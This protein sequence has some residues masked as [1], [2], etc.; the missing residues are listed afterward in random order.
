MIV[1]KKYR[2]KISEVGKNAQMT[3]KALLG[4][5]EDVACIHSDKIGYGVVDTEVTN[6]AWL[7]IEWKL[8]IIKRPK[9]GE[10]VIAKTWSKQAKKCYAFRDFELTDENGQIIAIATSKWVLINV[11]KGKIEKAEGE[12]HGKY[13]PEPEKK[14][15]ENESFEKISEPE[16]YEKEMTYKVRRADIDT[17]NHM[18]NLNYIELANEILPEEIYDEGESNNIRI[19]YKKE[20]KFTET[21]KIK[22][23]TKD[24]KNIICIKSEDGNTTHA[25]IELI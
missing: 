11:K 4:L 21:V 9:Y 18:H 2:V 8:K 7:V 16:K 12:V 3:N 24:E 20:I 22:Y 19:T 14:V 13:E 15:F 10:E 17:N 5:F 1:E 6:I 25:L 23:G